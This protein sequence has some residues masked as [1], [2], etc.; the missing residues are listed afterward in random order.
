MDA[1]SFMDRCDIGWKIYV[2]LL[3]NQ[4]DMFGERRGKKG[5]W[6]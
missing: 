2:Q 6:A 1:G 3:N 4:P 5:E